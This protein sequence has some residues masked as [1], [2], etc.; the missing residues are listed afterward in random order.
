MVDKRT[1]LE[2]GL[3]QNLK[4]YLDS[5]DDQS[6]EREIKNDPFLSDMAKATGYERKH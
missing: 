4:I 3:A 6:Y 5:L 1:I 2:H